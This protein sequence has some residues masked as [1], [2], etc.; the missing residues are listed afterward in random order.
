MS[1]IRTS[2]LFSLEDTYGG[3]IGSGNAW[4]APPPS[5]YF[6]HT[7]KR[8]TTRLQSTGTK[9]FDTIAYGKLSGSWNWKFVLDYNYLE[10][11]ALMFDGFDPEA[12]PTATTIGGQTVY[13]YVFNK[14]DYKRIPSFTVRRL[15][16]NRM[17]GGGPDEIETLTGCVCETVKFVRAAGTSQWQVTMSGFYSD[18]SMELGQWDGTDYQEYQG[19]LVEYAC[20]FIEN[21]QN[22]DYMANTESLEIT[23]SNSAEAI[24]NVCSPFAKQFSEGT[25]TY[26]YSVV[27]YSN[28]P[29][30]WQQRVFSG[31]IDNTATRPWAKGMAP[32]PTAHI[33]SY[34]QELGEGVS[35][36]REAFN[37]SPNRMD[38]EMSQCVVSSLQWQS[39]EGE[40]LRD[41][42]SS[43]E[44]RQ[45]AITALSNVSSFSFKAS[46]A[47]PHKVLSPV[48]TIVPTPAEEEPQ[49]SP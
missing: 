21:L 8:Q 41:S 38:F 6:D 13:Q 28:I 44:C 23:I 15:Q 35:T 5:S 47:N 9:R 24:Y 32:I 20:L 17:A 33:I 3:G 26:Q 16:L 1:S 12:A 45:I 2:F 40:R 37:S 25:T 14:R 22:A 11:L 42:I 34:N 27:A 30:N 39:G 29:A 4:I 46:G 49:S 19:N 18:E 36:W 10:P 31:G 7:N 48:G 43:E